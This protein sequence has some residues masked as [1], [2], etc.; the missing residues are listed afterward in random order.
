LVERR[1]FGGSYSWR[2][3]LYEVVEVQ[4]MNSNYLFYSKP[5]FI[6]FR[7]LVKD[8]NTLENK[9][10]ARS[11]R[12]PP[13]RSSHC[14]CQYSIPKVIEQQSTTYRRSGRLQI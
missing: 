3:A 8:Q 10:M 12:F 5:T 14:V 7:S 1:W 13:T 6:G 9:K 4:R 11:H 2:F